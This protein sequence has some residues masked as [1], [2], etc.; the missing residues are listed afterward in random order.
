[1]TSAHLQNISEIIKILNCV[2]QGL[3][4]DREKYFDL[5]NKCNKYTPAVEKHYQK[6]LERG[7]TMPNTN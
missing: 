5:A 2:F 7:Q 1:M 4:I 3:P 6:M